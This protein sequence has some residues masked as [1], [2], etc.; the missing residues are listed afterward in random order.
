MTIQEQQMDYIEAVKQ[1]IGDKNLKYHI[2]TY[3]CQM[4]VHDSEKLA[5]MLLEMGYQETPTIEEADLILFNTCCVREHAEQRVY[6]NVG[7]L[8]PYKR[9]K[10]NMIIGV[11]G[12]MMQQKGAADELIEKFP[13][14]DL[15]FGTHNLHHFPK[16]LYQ[17]LSAG[18]SVVEV[19]DEEGG[20]IEGLRPHRADGISAYVTIMYGCNNF[21]TYCIVPY[22]RGRERS[23]RPQDILDE[24]RELAQ[25]GY[26]EITLLGQNVN[27]YG[28]DLGGE[29]LFPDL[30]RDVNK[31][32][33][34]ER[35]RFVTSH[36]K[37]LSQALID[38]MAECEKVCEHIHLPLQAGS[39]RILH[40][41]NR[42]Y[43]RDDYLK[44]V[45]RLRDRIPD[46][47]ITTDLIVGFPGE[48]EEDFQ[49]TLDMVRRVQ[50]DSAYMFMYSPRR[51]TPAAAMP[52]QVDQ[53]VKKD[54]LNRLIELQTEISKAKNQQYLDRVVEVLVEG[55]S[56]NNPAK[57][58]GRTRTNKLVHFEGDE[59]LTGQ[60]VNVKITLPKAW[61]LDGVLVR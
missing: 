12:C 2:V 29:Y 48:T 9:K 52:D 26:K 7:M 13:F 23:R 50:Y 33:G 60:L 10:P 16:L 6:G 8:Q 59:G 27:S 15:V 32:D 36:P 3:G 25:Q 45:E 30:L 4:N 24:V 1:L 41:M 18:H 46:I 40:K 56:K 57:L 43:T 14:V 5:G 34:I 42:K 28:K 11:C 22:V 37:D 19:L 54:R 49:D 38:A 47:A 21:C 39:D 53:E 51:G 55:V 35:I 17:A 58:A 44:L 61:T 20:I 31:I